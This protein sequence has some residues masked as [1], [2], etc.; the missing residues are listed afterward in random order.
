TA[1]RLD[2]LLMFFGTVGALGA[3]AAQPA[4]AYLLGRFTDALWTD[5][6]DPEDF[7]RQFGQAINRVAVLFVITAFGAMA[8]SF[9][10]VCQ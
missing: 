7:K 1:D 9:M 3:G 6:T 10:Q 2:Y 4:F 5:G 8:M